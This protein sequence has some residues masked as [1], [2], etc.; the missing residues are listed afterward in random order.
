MLW[1]AG[2]EAPRRVWVHGWLLAQGERMSKSR[3]NFF[4][5]NAMVDALGVDGTRYV[6]LR[7]AAFDRDADVEL[8]QLPAAL[9]RGPGQRLGATSSTGP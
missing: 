7:E 3:G 6:L 4:D 8:G 2:L 1:S 9:Q 5:P